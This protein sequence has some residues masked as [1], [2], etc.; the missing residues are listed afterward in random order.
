MLTDERICAGKMI[1]GDSESE[2]FQILGECRVLGFGSEFEFR[3]GEGVA[4]IWTCRAPGARLLLIAAALPGFVFI[5]FC[6]HEMAVSFAFARM[7]LLTRDAYS[8]CAVAGAL[9]TCTELKW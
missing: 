6:Y 5:S 7:C 4:G 3:V 9:G 2:I 8:R 1:A